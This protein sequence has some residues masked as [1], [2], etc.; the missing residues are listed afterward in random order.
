VANGWLSPSGEFYP[1]K[2]GYHHVVAKEIIEQY[3][4]TWEQD[5]WIAVTPDDA[6]SEKNPT[7]KQI[8][9]LMRGKRL[10]RE[11]ARL[12][13]EKCNKRRNGKGYI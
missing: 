7:D 3:K 10:Y 12:M 11:V 5:T 1:C 8:K 6:F 9:W 2:I 4:D 13:L